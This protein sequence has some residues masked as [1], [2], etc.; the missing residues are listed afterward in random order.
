MPFTDGT[1][2]WRRTI[3]R[4]RIEIEIAPYRP[5]TAAEREAAREAAARHAA[6][7]GLPPA[8]TFR[9]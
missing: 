4:S 3:G 9:R 7:V 1:W 6:F 2:I 8:I 5:L